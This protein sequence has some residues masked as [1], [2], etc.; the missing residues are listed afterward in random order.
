M[1][2]TTSLLKQSESGVEQKTC[3]ACS[4]QILKTINSLGSLACDCEMSNYKNL[5]SGINKV[6]EGQS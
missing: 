5:I 6:F 2:H 3:D 1:T 4:Y